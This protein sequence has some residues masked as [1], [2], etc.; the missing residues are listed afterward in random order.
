MLR[1]VQRRAGDRLL[2]LSMALVSYVP[3]LL[4]RPGQV[5]ADT[6]QYLYLDPARLTAGAPSMWDPNVGL[7]TVTH[8]NI[9]Y[10]FPM[11]PYYT[12]AAWLGV[13]TWVAERLWMGSLLFA[14]GMGVAYCARR[15]GLEGPGRVLSC[16]VYA[17]SP[18]VI[19][20]L[21]RTSAL[22]MP[23][24]GLGWMLGF[25]IL[26]AR[27]GRWRYPAAFALVVA[28]VGG[29][30]ATSVV[31]VLLAPMAWLAHATWVS[32]EVTWRQ[33]WRA[34]WRIS[35]LSVGV[36]LWWAAGLLVEDHYGIDVLRVTETIPTVSRTSAAS[37]VLRG[38][39]YW[40]FYGWDKVQPWTLAAVEYTQA[41]WL[42]ALSLGLP[43]LFV[44]LGL[45][46][47]WRY[48]SFALGLVGLGTALAVGA[49]PYAHPSLWGSLI[50]GA[51]TT[52][53]LALAMRSVNRVVPVVVLGLALLAGSGVSALYLRAPRLGLVV[54]AVC[55]GLAAGDLP[56]LWS[57]NIVAAN[58]V[59]PSVLPSWWTE[60]TSYLNSLGGS[61]RVLGLPGE[62]FAAYSWGVTMDPIAPGLLRRPWVSR[63]VVPEG[64]PPA[65]NLLQALD[66]PLEEGTL[67][68]NAI[69]PVAALM[70]ASQVLLQSDLQY[71][72]YHLPL[73]QYLWEQLN[74]PPPGLSGPITF[75]PPDL[76]PLIRYPYVTERR[77]A[78][79]PGAPAPPA[80]AVYDV[81]DPRPVMRT[82][83]LAE[84]L[85]LAGDGSGVVEAASAGLL[86]GNPAVFYAASLASHPRLAQRTLTE[87]PTLVLTDTNPLAVDTWGSLR[88]NTG[89]VEQPG[90]PPLANDP[91]LYALP[92]FPGETT[93]DETVAQVSGVVRVQATNYGDS[94]T[95]TPEDKPINAFDRN[96]RTA[97]TFGA[98]SRVGGEAIKVYLAH[99]V[100]TDH[101][102]VVQAQLRGGLSRRRI[103]EVT[104]SFDGAHPVSFRLSRAS[105][106][107]G[108]Q[109]LRFP[110]RSFS[111]FE[112]RVDGAT[113]GSDKLYDGLAPVGFAEIDIPGVPPASETLRMPTDLLSLAGQSNL[114]DP[115]DVLMSRHRTSEPPRSD[116]ERY[117]A[118]SFYLPQAR[119]FSVSGTAEINW[120]DS[121]YLINQL[122]GLTPPGRLPAPDASGPGPAYLVAANS[123]TRLDA[124]RFV[125]ANA[126]F[127]N[128]P[129]TAWVAETGPQDGEWI[130]AWLDRPISFDHLHFVFVN[131]GLHSL[132][133]QV[134][135]TTASGSDVVNIPLPAVGVGR[136]AGA[137]SSVELSFPSLSGSW[138]KLTVDKVRA[139]TARDYYSTFKVVKDILP[140]GIA[141]VGLPGVEAPAPPTSLPPRCLG[142]L[143]KVNGQPVDLEV[144]G[145]TQAALGG[146]QLEVR[147]CGNSLGGIR[148]RAGLNQVVTSPRLPSGWSIDQLWLSSAPGGGPGPLLGADA[149]VSQPARDVALASASPM[150]VSNRSGRTSDQ[151]TIDGDGAGFWLVLGQSYSVGWQ[152]HLPGGRSL[153]QPVLIDGFANGWWVPAGLVRSPT[154]VTFSWVPQRVV[155]AA[156][157]ASGVAFATSAYL[158][159]DIPAALRRRRRRRHG[160]THPAMGTAGW[161]LVTEGVAPEPASA[162][163]LAGEGGRRPPPGLVLRASLGFCL[164][165]LVF[166]NPVLAATAAAA[167]AIACGWRWGRAV[168][169]A[170]AVGSLAAVAVYDLT[171]QWS[172]H[173]V[174]DI[175]WPANMSLANDLA[176]MGL[177]LLGADLVAGAARRRLG[178]GP[179][180]SASLTGERYRQLQ[181]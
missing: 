129:D 93:A 20:Y 82:E 26:A 28:A 1:P 100:T 114:A 41:G 90:A 4:A 55:I 117:L 31:L 68:A 140:V 163:A 141:E 138:V 36:S 15:L 111:V 101:I 167:T 181:P 54:G 84:P 153:G 160:V 58:L 86:A 74:P 130:K 80:L 11:G 116:P 97:W 159:V 44:A 157:G 102:K 150:V 2:A 67:D 143:L 98:H 135:I 85:V 119:T 30:N 92:V 39:G 146:D 72:R 37:E 83:P 33:A 133:S 59:R 21:D 53:T 51:P 179:R 145:S 46:T 91:S 7:G 115:L 65:A 123:S 105:L 64:T 128:N 178:G 77:L 170:G 112:L 121:D 45:L 104:L 61:E 165:A 95:S 96:L 27:S 131:D 151:V 48:R 166:T 24:A 9:G 118:R 127:D 162:S 57:G 175:N 144:T 171:Q 81:A 152:A 78:L 168:T 136:P 3:L 99:P 89:M 17:L 137:T 22:L 132:P 49:F 8:Q 6:K 16:F 32:R 5:A 94:L 161:A 177:V 35:L 25:C 71:E 87:D 43:A 23:W 19:D 88:D 122:I 73:P 156:L 34:G 154:V 13:P 63:Q 173:Y 147:P 142:G 69:A 60:A 50:K 109:V 124:D 79:P 18:Y 40:Y 172:H 47:R 125:R 164:L 107:P 52:S 103:T 42:I 149:S 75:G 155:W 126:A 120:R 14:A 10:L 66:E 70:S 110:R 108:G 169:R 113:G 174:P 148:L 62:D 139:V 76:A 176:W 180:A 134:T 12:L 38:L 56:P 106:L 158:A 29:V